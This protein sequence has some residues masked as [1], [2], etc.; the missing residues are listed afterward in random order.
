MANCFGFMA[1][2]NSL[3]EIFCTRKS[4]GSCCGIRNCFIMI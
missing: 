4:A 3:D 1:L 2:I